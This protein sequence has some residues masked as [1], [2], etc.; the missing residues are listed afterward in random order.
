MSRE[1][2]ESGPSLGDLIGGPCT[3]EGT[4]G[5][6]GLWEDGGYISFDPS[7]SKCTWPS[8]TDN[9]S[10]RLVGETPRPGTRDSYKLGGK[11]DTN[12]FTH[13]TNTKWGCS[14]CELWWW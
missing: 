7:C 12:N 13:F 1:R 14:L 11:N 2:E 3:M 9:V 10:Q 4:R 6:E 8:Q 5:R